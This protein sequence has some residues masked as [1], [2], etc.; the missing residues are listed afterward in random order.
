MELTPLRNRGKRGAT[1]WSRAR[2]RT[3]GH[4]QKTKIQKATQKNI[5]LLEKLSRELVERI[6]LASENLALP[7]CSRTLYHK[8]G[9]ESVKQQLL[10]AAFSPTWDTWYDLPFGDLKSYHGWEKD[11]KRV[12]GDPKFQVSPVI[13]RCL[14]TPER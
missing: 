4:D 8:L 2:N 5:S 14:S 11:N 9:S 3:A 6:F 7:R 1:P 10:I 12:S 13:S